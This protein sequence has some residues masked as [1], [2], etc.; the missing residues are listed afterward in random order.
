MA[1][2]FINIGAT[3]AAL[4]IILGAF[5]AHGLSAKLEPRMLEVWQTAVDYHLYHALGL[6]LVGI[7][8]HQ[9]GG[10]LIKWSGILMLIGTLLFSGSIYLLT[11]TGLGWLGMI[12]PFGGMSFIIAWLLLALASL[13]VNY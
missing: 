7:F 5:G 6:I 9:V 4:G 11:L 2:F 12:T 1:K 3:L 10:T 8:L 13:R